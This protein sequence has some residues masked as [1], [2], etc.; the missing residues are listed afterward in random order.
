M[1]TVNLLPAWYLQQH[2]QKRNSRLHV[3]CM[4]ALAGLMAGAWSLSAKHIDFEQKQRDTLQRKLAA[5]PDPRTSLREAK[6]RLE[7]L[8]NRKKACSELGKTIPVSCILQQLQND[9][10]DGMALSRVYLEVRPGP[11]NGA[12]NADSQKPTR[13][14]DVAYLSV[15]GIAPNDVQITTFWE[16]LSKNPL[17]SEVNL[18]HTRAG[19]LQTYLVRRFELKMKMDLERLTTENPDEDTSSKFASG[20]P[21]NG[22]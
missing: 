20:G 17:F 1:K 19:T 7:Y 16:H 2:R 12:G 15:E 10:T 14:H 18:E 3:L 4:L 21:V 22:Q 11:V 6:V 5:T 8:E 9:M 13:L